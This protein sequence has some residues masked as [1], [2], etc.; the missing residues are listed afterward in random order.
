M[1]NYE[2]QLIPVKMVYSKSALLYILGGNAQAC[3]GTRSIPFPYPAPKSQWSE[4]RRAELW[5]WPK[6]H[7]KTHLKTIKRKQ[8][9][10]QNMDKTESEQKRKLFRAWT[11]QHLPRGDIPSH[12]TFAF[13]D[14]Y[15]GQIKNVARS[16]I[17]DSV[18]P[19]IAQ[20]DAGTQA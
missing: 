18:P 19:S 15:F 14:T 12:G 7:H 20:I 13:L 9:S 6:S 2:H 16:H 17:S 3:S 4:P 11:C 5:T 1:N 8:I 10:H